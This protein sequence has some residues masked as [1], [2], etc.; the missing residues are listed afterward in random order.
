M[1][2]TEEHYCNTIAKAKM[3]ADVWCISALPNQQP[4][5]RSRVRGRAT[6]Y[7]GSSLVVVF[8]PAAHY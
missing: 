4:S 3:T 5:A 1:N 2:Y 7:V 8:S 6:M